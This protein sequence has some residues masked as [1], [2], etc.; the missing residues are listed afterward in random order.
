MRRFWK[1]VRRT[2][3]AV[4]LVLAV[5]AIVRVVTAGKPELVPTPNLYADSDVNPFA[6]VPEEFRNN[7]VDVLYVTDRRRVAG[8][9]QDMVAYD[10]G[11][12]TSMAFGS[13]VI[14][15]GENV[16]WDELVK[17]SRSRKRDISLPRELVKVE[18]KGRFP[19]TPWP[20][21]PSAD[22]SDHRL[23]YDP[24]VVAEQERVAEL[25]RNEVRARLAKT[26]KKEVYVF[27]HGY[28]NDFEHAVSVIAAIW[29]F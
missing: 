5:V 4:V 24:K 23:H 29:H 21:D 7:Q 14:Q 19:P 11:R 20:F 12:S 2:L 15:Y 25:F 16:T 17:A 13:A 3:L 8:A 9:A 22:W 10:H 28:N 26:P 27:V 18:E 1:F 6:D